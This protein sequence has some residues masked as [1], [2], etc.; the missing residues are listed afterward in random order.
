MQLVER[1]LS[2]KAKRAKMYKNQFY[3]TPSLRREFLAQLEDMSIMTDRSAVEYI[4]RHGEWM[5]G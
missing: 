2:Y 3:L 4:D 5:D 1:H